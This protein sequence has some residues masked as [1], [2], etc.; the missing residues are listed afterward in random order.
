MGEDGLIYLNMT[1]ILNLEFPSWEAS[2]SLRSR[3]R[4][5]GGCRRREGRGYWDWYVKF[6]LKKIVLNFF[7]VS[8]KNLEFLG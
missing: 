7:N 8:E 5:D 1:F 4:W 6:F 2:P 3:W